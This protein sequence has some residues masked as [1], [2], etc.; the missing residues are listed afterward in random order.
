MCQEISS[1]ERDRPGGKETVKAVNKVRKE[2]IDRWVDAQNIYEFVR[3][4]E[5]LT[6]I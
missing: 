6:E 5:N 4:S 3:Y 1:I 2:G